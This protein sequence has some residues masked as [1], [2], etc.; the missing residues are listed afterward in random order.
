[1]NVI[2]INEEIMP[3]LLLAVL[4]FF[5]RPLIFFAIRWAELRNEAVTE[6][7]QL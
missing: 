3:L 6:K 2:V 1:M 7:H 5:A 4:L